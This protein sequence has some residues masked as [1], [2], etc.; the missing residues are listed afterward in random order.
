MAQTFTLEGEMMYKRLSRNKKANTQALN[1]PSSP[2][3]LKET[4]T[5]AEIQVE[6]YRTELVDLIE[7]SK[8]VVMDCDNIIS[9]CETGD[10]Y[11][12]NDAKV[13]K[14]I[15]TRLIDRYNRLLNYQSALR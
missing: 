12:R 13:A 1:P 15:H 2:E 14:M 9:L 8:R 3:I 6:F 7:N 5:L 4:R 11:L 10:E